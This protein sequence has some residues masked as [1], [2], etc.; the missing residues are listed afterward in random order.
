VKG[1]NS[2]HLQSRGIFIG[3]KILPATT[4]RDLGL[5]CTQKLVPFVQFVLL[6]ANDPKSK[7]RD[8]KIHYQFVAYSGR[9]SITIAWII[10]DGY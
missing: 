3:T 4:I 1:D 5:V 2:N 7:P 8:L 6:Y 10:K 9:D